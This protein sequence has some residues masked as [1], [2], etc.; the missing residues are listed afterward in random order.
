M[1]RQLV[2][3]LIYLTHT[4]PDISYEVRVASKHMDKPHDI[5]CM[6]A[7][8]IL[9]F[10]QRTKTH[11]IHNVG[12]S[13]LELVGFTDSDWEGDKADIKLWICVYACIWTNTM[14]K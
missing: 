2:G 10:V 13:S 5:H 12:Q 3:C 11:G 9:N 7:K 4:Q 8:R 6:E 14:F 1:Y